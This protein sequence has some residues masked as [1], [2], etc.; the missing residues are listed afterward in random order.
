MEIMNEA[1]W[2][3][4]FYRFV[5]D[6]VIYDTHITMSIRVKRIDFVPSIAIPL[7]ISYLGTKGGSDDKI[8][9]SS[10]GE[11]LATLRGRDQ[12]PIKP[13]PSRCLLLVPI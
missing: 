7:G 3:L 13:T 1:F 10:T 11:A 6:C 12:K 8:A 5:N 4:L 9:L 2:V